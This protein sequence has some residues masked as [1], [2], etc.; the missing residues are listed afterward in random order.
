MEDEATVS[1]YLEMLD[2]E[3]RAI[4][5]VKMDHI[6]ALAAL[7][8]TRSEKAIEYKYANIS[9][10]LRDFGLPFIDGYKPRSNYQQLLWDVVSSRVGQSKPLL[11]LIKAQVE[12]P[13]VV[14]TVEDILALLVEPPTSGDET[15]YP[16]L[17]QVKS[18]GNFHPV[19]YLE[20]EARNQS[21][22]A[23]GEELVLR[24]EAGPIDEA[25]SGQPGGAG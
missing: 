1:D 5:F 16:K 17:K 9:A 7:L 21:L 12:A 4:S 15:P 13:A 14:P 23:A 10:V 3:L 24:Y 22:G 18:R 20:R 6:R 11:T 8:G 19:N 2:L 25:G